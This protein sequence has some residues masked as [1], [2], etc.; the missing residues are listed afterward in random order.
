MTAKR[1][2]YFDC[3]F[4]NERH[5]T[6]E[7]LVNHIA[8]NHEDELPE[9][10]TPL[11]YTFNYVNRKPIEYHGVCTE[12]KR[13]TPWDEKVGRYKRQCGR[14][15]CHESYL[16]KFEN[17]MLR[18]MKVKRI[19]QTVEGQEKMLANRKISGVYKFKNGKEKGYTGKYELHCLEF[20]DKIM[21]IDPDDL[22]SP[23]PI[24][25][26]PYQGSEHPYIP[27]FYYQPYNLLI[28]VKD[29]GNNP[30]K[31]S[32]PDTR[33][34]Q[35]AKEK[36]VI[37]NTNYNYIRLTGDDLSQL[38][39][40]FADLKMKMVENSG[41]RVIHVNEVMNA[42]LG[43]PPVGVNDPDSVYIIN[44]MRKNVF[45]GEDEE[46]DYALSVEPT[47][48]KLIARGKDGRLVK[49]DGIEFLKNACYN[50]YKVKVTEDILGKINESID[51]FVEEGFIFETI[52]GKK[53]YTNDQIFFEARCNEN[54]TPVIDHYAK[55]DMIQQITENFLLRNDNPEKCI[56]YYENDDIKVDINLESNS[57]ILR[58]KNIEGNYYL[59]STDPNTFA[60]DDKWKFIES[61]GRRARLHGQV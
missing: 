43:T 32:M 13:E 44:H 60:D 20:L 2:V 11:R 52:F 33:A 49:E 51:E 19:S 41:E 24:L 16:K 14:K 38:L 36:F 29:G 4:C 8:D 57:Y 55:M 12:C 7:N 40:I 37:K 39:S 42:L 9:E 30:N 53:L 35:I 1:I 18:T 50:V 56:K 31:K 54:V 27:D 34:R 45:S 48:K 17:N 6:R 23:G 61:I 28:E 3:P 47:L 46:P 58:P 26:Y 59:E 10:F 22:M 21:N 15:E 25:Y 5:L